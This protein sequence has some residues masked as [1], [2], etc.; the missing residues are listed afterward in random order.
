MSEEKKDKKGCCCSKDGKACCKFKK[1][2]PH[3]WLKLKGLSVLF[4]ILFYAAI[5]GF[6]YMCVQSFTVVKYAKIGLV[7]PDN[8]PPVLMLTVSAF[9]SSVFFLTFAKVTKA[10]AKIKHILKASCGCESKK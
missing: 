5:I 7:S 2:F 6:I 9:L 10:L 4:T 1:F 8:V 3:N